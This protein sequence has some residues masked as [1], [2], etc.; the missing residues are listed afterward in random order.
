MATQP[1]TLRHERAN[2]GDRPTA[3]AEPTSLADHAAIRAGVYRAASEVFRY[4]QATRIRWIATA[5]RELAH[6]QTAVAQFASSATWRE[7]LDAL[8]HLT[9]YPLLDLER[10][11]VAL[12]MVGDTD[13]LCP[14]YESVYRE[15]QGS[16]SGWLQARVEGAYRAASI[17]APAGQGELP[18]HLATELAFLAIL[19][20]RESEAWERND[21]TA[22]S[23]AQ[24]HQSAFIREH[25]LTWLPS[26]G[27]Q[28]TRADHTGVYA[29]IAREVAI[30]IAY[31][32]DLLDVL[33]QRTTPASAKT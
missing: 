3:L 1:P 6:E 33:R 15:P 5:S 14:P 8:D 18:D 11:Y 31:D 23:D 27:Q 24:A 26:L 28:L 30:Y 4:P 16:P 12:F 19:A 32:C 2:G 7:L 10:H 20:A 13:V 9:R 17:T 22:A 25:V 29:A 21:E